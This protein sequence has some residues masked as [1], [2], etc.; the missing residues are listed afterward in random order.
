MN[1]PAAIDSLSY[2]TAEPSR[3]KASLLVRRIHMFTG[4]FLGPWMLMYALS[5]LVMTHRDYVVSFYP[6]KNPVM[7]TERQLN[8]ARSFPEGMSREQIAHQ[9]LV[10][11]GLDGANHVSG[12]QN[13]KPL[14]ITRQQ[15][16][17]A[18]R[19]TFDA[20]AEKLVLAREEFR[21]LTFLERM[22]R[23]RGYSQPYVSDGVW[24]L[25]VDLAVITMAFWSLSGIWLWWELKS[26][27]RLGAISFVAGLSLFALFLVL[28]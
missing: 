13:G 20:S 23:R 22:H 1:V 10:D 27:H 9:L 14:I 12:G 4:L 5:T 7:I 3:S 2:P 28:L 15:G 17:I 16:L 19:I 21:A 11:L 24:G 18:R 26:T 25:S 8:Y 6:T